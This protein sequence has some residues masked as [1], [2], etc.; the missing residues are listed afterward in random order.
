M[1]YKGVARLGGGAVGITK[2]P[3][4]FTII[5]FWFDAEE[6]MGIRFASGNGVENVVSKR[7]LLGL[8]KLV[9]S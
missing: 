5:W 9:K 8:G 3:V 1:G 4:R 6:V 2:I 7:Y